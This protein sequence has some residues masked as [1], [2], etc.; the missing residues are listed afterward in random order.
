MSTGKVHTQASLM[1][2]AGFLVGTL[3]T[4]DVSDVE[5]AIGALVGTILTPDLDVDKGFVGDAYVKARFGN[6]AYRLWRACWHFYRRSVKHGS[7]LS[8]FPV[9][10][11]LF[12]LAYLFFF[13]II[14][15]TYALAIFFP[16]DPTTEIFWWYNLVMSHPKIIIGLM[17]SDAHHYV[18]DIATVDSKFNLESLLRRKT[19]FRRST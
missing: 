10:G 17:A 12:R 2:S 18:M 7:E 1:M 11:T 13:S 16:I 6:V 15:P 3:F 9:L 8:H 5:Y 4:R 19:N 14:L